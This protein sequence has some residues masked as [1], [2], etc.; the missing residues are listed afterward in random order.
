M[1]P[2]AYAAARAL[3]QDPNATPAERE[4]AARRCFEYEVLHGGPSTTYGK[5][6][7]WTLKISAK[8][9]GVWLDNGREFRRAL[10]ALRDGTK[11]Y[12]YCFEWSTVKAVQNGEVDWVWFPDR[13]PWRMP[14]EMRRSASDP[15]AVL[16][17]EISHTEEVMEWV[18]PVVRRGSPKKRGLRDGELPGRRRVKR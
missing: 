5:R 3:S 12:D 6:P 11:Q 18:P 13:E 7:W 16:D 4:N 8:E 2:R 9:S 1:T 14:Q 10:R 15:L 17:R